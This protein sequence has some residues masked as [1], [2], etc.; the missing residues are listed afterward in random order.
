MYR[1][2]HECKILQILLQ[3]WPAKWFYLGKISLGLR[4]GGPVG[5]TGGSAIGND[6]GLGVGLTIG[7]N[8]PPW[9]GISSPP[10]PGRGPQPC[11]GDD[12]PLNVRTI[13]KSL[14]VSWHFIITDEFGKLLTAPPVMSKTFPSPQILKQ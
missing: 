11:G 7:G 12:Q 13:D 1:P 5:L 8:R 10:N 14:S 4:S 2:L 6:G 3:L 9:G